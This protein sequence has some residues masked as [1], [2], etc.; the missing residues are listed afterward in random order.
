MLSSSWHD[1][2]IP[3]LLLEGHALSVFQ[4][5]SSSSIACCGKKCF[6]VQWCL[7]H[8]LQFSRIPYLSSLS[9]NGIHKS[10]MKWFLR[11]KCNDRFLFCPRASRHIYAFSDHHHYF[12]L[13][14]QYINLYLKYNSFKIYYII[15]FFFKNTFLD[16]FNNNAP[17]ST[18]SGNLN[19]DIW[20]EYTRLANSL[21]SSS[22]HAKFLKISTN[23]S[24]D[25]G[26]WQ[27]FLAVVIHLNKTMTRI[28]FQIVFL[29]T[30]CSKVIYKV[31]SYEAAWQSRYCELKDTL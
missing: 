6:T 21:H 1:D 18:Q 7:K 25:R 17:S 26:L 22:I 20:T 31:P 16:T 24:C 9:V 8:I 11:D 15:D 3:I 23:P 4:K 30:R 10:T 13:S 28:F 19:E 27:K 5:D 2:L 29:C 12:P 14:W